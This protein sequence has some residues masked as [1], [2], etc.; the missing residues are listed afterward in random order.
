MFC[1]LFTIKGTL[2]LKRCYCLFFYYKLNSFTSVVLSWLQKSARD[3]W[4]TN[5]NITILNATCSMWEHAWLD[6]WISCLP[7]AVAVNGLVAF[8]GRRER[9]LFHWLISKAECHQD[10][11]W[12][13]WMKS[14]LSNSRKIYQY[15]DIKEKKKE[16][17]LEYINF[18]PCLSC[19]LKSF[20]SLMHRVWE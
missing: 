9:T 20:T 5:K 11:Y 15:V 4:N 8:V 7:L 13:C 14:S 1:G 12:L 3:I 17:Q 19:P 6:R 2:L 16:K 18:L 10:T